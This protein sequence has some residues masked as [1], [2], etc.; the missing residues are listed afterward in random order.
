MNKQSR[1]AIQYAMAIMNIP[2]E[3]KLGDQGKGLSVYTPRD[4]DAKNMVSSASNGEPIKHDRLGNNLEIGMKHYHH[5]L[6]D[7][8]G[9]YPAHAFY[10]APMKS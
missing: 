9:K 10:G 1:I 6:H 2:D 4:L 3:N 5:P 7:D 8:K